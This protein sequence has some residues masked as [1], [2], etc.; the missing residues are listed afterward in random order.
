MVL[1]KISL[2]KLTI[3]LIKNPNETN[4]FCMG[5]QR[6]LTVIDEDICKALFQPPSSGKFTDELNWTRVEDCEREEIVKSAKFD[7]DFIGISGVAQTVLNCVNVIE[8]LGHGTCKFYSS[9]SLQIARCSTFKRMLTF[10]KCGDYL[11]GEPTTI[12]EVEASE[13]DLEEKIELEEL[14]GLKNDP[15][16]TQVKTSIM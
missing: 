6:E 8:L 1:T 3:F 13:E 7:I 10:A 15:H 14:K 2:Q 16:R 11:I 12:S 4:F 5:M 9:A